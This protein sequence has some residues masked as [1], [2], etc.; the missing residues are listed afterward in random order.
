MPRSNRYASNWIKCNIIRKIFTSTVPRLLVVGF[1]VKMIY[2][3]VV[4]TRYIAS[5][6]VNGQLSLNSGL[7]T[8]D[9]G[10]LTTLG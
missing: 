4:E 2:S 9:F 1:R 10:L 6:R 8:I 7:L 3:R 5:V